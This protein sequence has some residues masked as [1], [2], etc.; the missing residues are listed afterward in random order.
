M[1]DDKTKLHLALLQLNNITEL[2]KD[3]PYFAFFTSHLLPIKYEIE[4]QL[5]LTNVNHST[6]IKE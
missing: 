5:V 1:I 3:G 2:L 4:R 6:T